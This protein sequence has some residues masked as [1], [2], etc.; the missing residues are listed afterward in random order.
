VRSN[1]WPTSQDCSTIEASLSSFQATIEA[2]EAEI[3]DLEAITTHLRF[4]L[5]NYNT[6][7]DFQRSL[8][9][10]IRKLPD[11]I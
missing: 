8:L 9:S 4:R 6:H 5:S 7:K 11:E 3:F 1:Y 10:P 2:L